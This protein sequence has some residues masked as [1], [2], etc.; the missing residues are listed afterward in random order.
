MKAL[1]YSL[2]YMI[3]IFLIYLFASKIY[4]FS[5]WLLGI[6]PVNFLAIRYGIYNFI[7]KEK[8]TTKDMILGQLL[9]YTSLFNIIFLLINKVNIFIMLIVL[10]VNFIEITFINNY[11]PT[12]KHS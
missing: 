9:I 3:I 7:D 11:K 10:A 6:I 1:K 5:F 4:T 12:K 2:G 8:Y